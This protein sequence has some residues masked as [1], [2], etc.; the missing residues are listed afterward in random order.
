MEELDLLKKDW[1]KKENSFQQI[2]E[3]DIYKMVH[4]QSSSIVKLILILSVLEV[5]LWSVISIFY[6]SD[7]YL[8]KMDSDYLIKYLQILN[9]VNYAVIAIFIYLFY[10]NYISISTTTSTKKL[11]KAI[12]KT[13]NTVQIYVWYNLV[14]IAIGMI[15]GMALAFKTNPEIEHM[16]D[17][18]KVFYIAIA[19]CIVALIIVF[20]LFW[21]FYR[22]VYG[23]LLRKLLTNYKELKK[24]DL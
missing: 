18:D 7:D 15:I 6:N 21:L 23:M 13:R 4:K 11:M 8:I 1:K 5:L 16:L 9:L 10:K 12:L 3:L 20:G 24:I 22:L 17:N 2:S 14:M 19:F